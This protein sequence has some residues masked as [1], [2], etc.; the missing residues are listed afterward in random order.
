LSAP[1]N[2]TIAAADV[3]ADGL[4]DIIVND[5]PS[6]FVPQAGAPGTFAPYRPLR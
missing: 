4:N 3:D 5:G 6:V 2:A 1:F